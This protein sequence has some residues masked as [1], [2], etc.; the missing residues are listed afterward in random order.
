MTSGVPRISL[1]EFE[2]LR[3]MAYCCNRRSVYLTRVILNPYRE[4]CEWGFP[5]HSDGISGTTRF[6][7]SSREDFTRLKKVVEK[8]REAAAKEAAL[9]K[10]LAEEMKALAKDPAIQGDDTMLD[11]FDAQE[12]KDVYF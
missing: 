11:E 12:Q 1:T 10:K 8:K 7:P 6:V 9:E 4:V 3:F 2:M 5:F